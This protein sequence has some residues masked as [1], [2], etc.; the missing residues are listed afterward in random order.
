M[1]VHDIRFFDDSKGLVTVKGNAIEKFYDASKLYNVKPASIMMQFTSSDDAPQIVWTGSKM[2]VTHS[3]NCYPIVQVYDNLN[4]Q[5]YP[6]VK[7]LDGNSFELDFTDN[8][9]PAQGIAWKCAITFGAEY[10]SS[11]SISTDVASALAIIQD[12]YDAMVDGETYDGSSSSGSPLVTFIPQ[13]EKNIS[14]G[15]AGLDVNGK[16]SRNALP[17]AGGGNNDLG[18]VAVHASY[19]IGFVGNVIATQKATDAQIDAGTNNYSAIVPSNLDYAVRSVLDGSV[20]IPAS[21]TAYTLLDSSSATNGHVHSYLHTPLHPSTYTLPAVSDTLIHE[22]VLEVRYAAYE[23]YSDGDDTGRYAWKCGSSVVYTST[24][25]P[26]AGTTVA[27]S[28]TGMTVAVETVALYES[29]MNAISLA[30][31]CEFEDAS[32]NAVVPT[33]SYSIGVGSVISYLCRYSLTLGEWCVLPVP[34]R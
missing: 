26:V 24:N 22:I 9:V 28:D 34:L 4:E 10:G 20:E 7:I 16:L 23:R 29:S 8:G 17:K 14:N 2:T 3:M 19:G 12:M 11:G 18:A 33:G 25:V 27:Y 30:G 31:S 5:V 32:G 1:R 13:S 6:T 21:T 15:V